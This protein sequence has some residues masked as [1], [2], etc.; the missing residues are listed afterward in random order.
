MKKLK[1]RLIFT[2][3]MILYLAVM[4]DIPAYADACA[5]LIM[6][7]WPESWLFLTLI[8]PIEIVVG[9]RVFSSS[10]TTTLKAVITANVVSTLFGIPLTSVAFYLFGTTIMHVW[11]APS[12]IDWTRLP[13]IQKIVMTITLSGLLHL[14]FSGLL[15]APLSD[16]SLSRLIPAMVLCI[17]FFFISV[18]LE[19]FVG[20]RFWGKEQRELVR[21]WA[22]IDNACSY[23]FVLIVL[24]IRLLWMLISG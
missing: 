5:P 20:R 9:L 11:G 18:L 22:W 6:L 21:R 19:Y 24:G 10:R 8:I 3:I 14:P 12:A 4:S 1:H 7:V 23:T 13:L 16:W 2:G 17:P 15:T